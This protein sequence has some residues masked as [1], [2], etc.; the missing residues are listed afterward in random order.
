M[1]VT[2]CGRFCPNEGV[3]AGYDNRIQVKYTAKWGVQIAGMIFKQALGFNRPSHFCR[4][5][6]AILCTFLCGRTNYIFGVIG[7]NSCLISC[8]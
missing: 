5:C 1:C 4:P 3:V 6:A 7:I 8:L 2:L